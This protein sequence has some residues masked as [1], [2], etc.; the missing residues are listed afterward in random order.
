MFSYII[1]LQLCNIFYI[2]HLGII[3]FQT[4]YFAMS[5]SLVLAL[6][7]LL[8]IP[9]TPYPS[10]PPCNGAVTQQTF[11]FLDKFCED[12]YNLYKID[13]IFNECRADCFRNDFFYFCMNVTLVHDD[14]QQKAVDHLVAIDGGQFLGVDVL[15]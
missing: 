11:L 10:S 12:C 2:F 4:L 3:L 8:T 9:T 13:E 5:L 14:T 1:F 7:S 15:S 6:L